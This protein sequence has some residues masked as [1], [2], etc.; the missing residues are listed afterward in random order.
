MDRRI[1]CFASAAGYTVGSVHTGKITEVLEKGAV[2]SLEENVEGFATPKHLVKNALRGTDIGHPPYDGIWTNAK[3]RMK[4]PEL[5]P[6][7]LLG[8]VVIKIEKGE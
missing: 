5:L 2:V 3:Y 8:P 6:A 1:R 7:G 4:T